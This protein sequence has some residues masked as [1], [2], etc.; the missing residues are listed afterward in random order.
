MAGEQITIDD[1]KVLK[2]FRELVDTAPEAV[3]QGLWLWGEYVLTEAI[4]RVP[5]DTGRLRAA[6][7]QTPT[8]REGSDWAIYLGFGTNYAA[9]VHERTAARHTTGEAKFLERALHHMAPRLMEVI[10]STATRLIKAGKAGR[11][12][13][14]R[15][16]YPN[17][18][19]SGGEG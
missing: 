2:R 4:R 5:V 12:R 8:R 3:A 14:G 13:T 11:V 19:P 9:A 10:E 15:G 18:P 7:F 1:A 16:K 17:R 6:A